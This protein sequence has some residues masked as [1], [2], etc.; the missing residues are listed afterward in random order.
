MSSLG[1]SLSYPSFPPRPT[2]NSPKPRCD[3]LY[4]VEKVPELLTVTSPHCSIH[5]LSLPVNINSRKSLASFI[6]V[7]KD[8]S[9]FGETCCLF[10]AIPHCLWSWGERLLP[11]SSVINADMQEHEIRH[12][13]LERKNPSSGTIAF[14]P[15]YKL[16][17]NYT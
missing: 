11:L 3:V 17:I 7:S 6:L 8:S 12:V 1:S 14:C 9:K 10:F 4:R 15:W 5:C 13:G 16:A 2:P